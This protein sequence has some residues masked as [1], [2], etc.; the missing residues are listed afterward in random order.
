MNQRER[1]AQAVDAARRDWMEAP[2]HV[3]A[4]AARYMEPVLKALLQVDSE[5]AEIRANGGNCQKSIGGV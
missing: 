3:K 1:T 2:A 5:L 4:I